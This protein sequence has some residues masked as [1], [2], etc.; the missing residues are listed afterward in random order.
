MTRRLFENPAEQLFPSGNRYPATLAKA[1]MKLKLWKRIS[2]VAVVCAVTVI[3]LPKPTY[4]GYNEKTILPQTFD[5]TIT[6]VGSEGFV[7]RVRKA[8]DLLQSKSSSGYPVV[9]QYIGRIQEGTTSGMYAYYNPPT[10]QMSAKEALL[11]ENN[12]EYAVQWCASIIVHDAYHSKKYHDYQQT[13]GHSIHSNPYPPTDVW[14]GEAVEREC[15]AFQIKVSR[16]IGAY[17]TI[18]EYLKRCDARYCEG[19]RSW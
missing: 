8:L 16:E 9:K 13:H 6:I 11:T 7:N 19:P 12:K 14:T 3:G 18:V 10:F 2:L 4:R 17:P 15:L 1:G 5:G